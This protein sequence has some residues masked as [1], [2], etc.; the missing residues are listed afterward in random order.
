M[1]YEGLLRPWLFR[2]DPEDAHYSMARMAKLSERLPGASALL[3]AR[4]AYR[5]PRLACKVAGIDFPN[6]VGMAAGFDKSGDLYPFLANMGFGYVESGT[7][8]ALEQPGNPRPRIFRVPEIEGLINRMGFNNPGAERQR[9][10]L[11]GKSEPYRAGSTSGRA[12]SQSWKLPPRTT[13][14]RCVCWPVLGITSA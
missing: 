12:N 10:F 6:P 3:R 2:K 13:S 5:S 9:R 1:L 4:F 8:T 14:L 7:F 11:Q